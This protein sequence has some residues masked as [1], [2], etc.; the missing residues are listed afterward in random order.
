MHTYGFSDD[1]VFTIMKI[2]DVIIILD[3]FDHGDI[4]CASQNIATLARGF[5]GDR[6]IGLVL[7]RTQM[8]T[9]WER[10]TAFVTAC[11]HKKKVTAGFILKCIRKNIQSTP[12]FIDSIA[13]RLTPASFPIEAQVSPCLVIIF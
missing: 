5:Y 12:G 6:A 7:S 3:K 8:A 2:V 13:D 4:P 11:W 10:A 1:K 9:D